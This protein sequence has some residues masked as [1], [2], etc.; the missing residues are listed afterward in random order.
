[1]NIVLK[2][3]SKTAV[4]LSSLLLVT[5]PVC[6]AQTSN[7][8]ANTVNPKLRQNLEIM[9]G[10][11]QKSLASEK[12][13]GIGRLEHHYILG[14]GVFFKASAHGGYGHFL[15]LPPLPPQAG[16]NDAELAEIVADAQAIAA[17]VSVDMQFDEQAFADINERAESLAEIASEQ[18][19]QM[20]EQLRDLREQKRDLERDLRDVE[21]EKTDIEFSQKVSKLP[22]EKQ[23]E[24]KVL[25]ERQASLQK[26]IS[27]VSN[28]FNAKDNELKQIR[29]EQQKAAEQQQQALINQV[30]SQLATTLCDFGASL[31]EL[32][33]QE[34]VAL[35]LS[36]RG[37]EGQDF[38]WVINK[39]DINQCVS[40]KIN[41]TTLLK[42]AAFYRY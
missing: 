19:Q 36:T 15:A 29:A 40:G 16:L 42:K 10:I 13:P 1:M 11:L 24:L 9:Q 23:Q 31:R 26:Q 39:S 38:Y 22:A 2:N 32:K 34:F 21:R 33:E 27:E 8:N 7:S 41:A 6:L 18:Q 12:N 17:E 3:M 25:N 37:R 28:K 4:V 20:R 30:G 35:Q 5:A 14:Q